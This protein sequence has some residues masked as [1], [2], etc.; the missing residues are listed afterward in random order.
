MLV[1]VAL[2]MQQ[3]RL[4]PRG[5]EFRLLLKDIQTRHGAKIVLRAHVVERLALQRDGF[6][7]HLDF[8]VGGP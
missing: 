1:L 7:E 3:T 8:V 6:V 2:L 4:Y 5:V